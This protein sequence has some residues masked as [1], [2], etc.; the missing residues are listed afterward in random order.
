MPGIVEVSEVWRSG[1]GGQ[2]DVDLVA[3]TP[4]PADLPAAVQL[5]ADLP[6]AHLVGR[7]M[8]VGGTQ[9][10]RQFGGNLDAGKSGAD[11]ERREL[12]RSRLAMRQA[13]DMVVETRGGLPRIDIECRSGEGR[14]GKLAAKREDEAVVGDGVKRA[15]CLVRNRAGRDIDAHDLAFDAANADRLEHA[16][17][18]HLG[19]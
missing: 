18:R 16:V 12:P 10:A 13:R 19:V 5:I 3:G 1:A 7:W 14:T 15:R 2:N 4:H 17:E 9:L 8:P 11:H 6:I